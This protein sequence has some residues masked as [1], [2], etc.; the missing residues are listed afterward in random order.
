MSKL[1]VGIDMGTTALKIAAF[2]TAG[3]LLGSATLEYTLYTP[4]SYFVESDPAVYMDA[5]EKGFAKLAE[6]GVPIKDVVAL[7]FSSQ[8]ETMFFVDENCKPLRNSISWMDNRA[9][10]Q[11][12]RLEKKYG[13]EL[14]YKHTG[15][16]SWGANWP[17]TKALWVKENEPEVWAKTKKILLIEDFIIYQLTGRYVA[18]CAMLT[19]TLYWDITTKKYWKLML[20]ELELTEDYFPEILEP[21]ELV[22][23]ILPDMAEKLGLSPDTQ[24]CTGAM[25]NAIGAL[26]VGAYRPGV[27]SE[28]IGST[29]AVCVPTDKVVYDPNQQMPVHYYT[30]KDTYMMHTFTS[31]GIC[32]RW[33]R[34][35]FCQMEKAMAEQ[36]G[37]DDYN[38]LTKQAE[39][40]PAGSDGLSFLPHLSGSLAPD[41]NPHATGIFMGITLM[42]TKGHFI[43]AIMESLGYLVRRNID[44]LEAMGLHIDEI[45]AFGGGSKSPLWNQ[46]NADILQ[47]TICVTS[48]KEAACLGAAIL[49]G[50]AVGIFD[51][52]EKACDSM[53]EVIARYEPSSENKAVYDH[54]YEIY[55]KMQTDC[56]QLFEMVNGND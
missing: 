19:S 34:D 6:K 30:M 20:D 1:L 39:N 17:A 24:I 26:G 42:H 10:E 33:F 45:R 32:M 41:V 54:G 46:I 4:Q 2:D 21:G 11:S 8:S 29:L 56:A 55:K 3:K 25:D 27:F 15:Q 23:K 22:G 50:Y 47:R 18:D 35:K 9:V 13:N 31:G 12:Q 7:G 52:I 43:R 36:L 16:V 28:S 44:A 49:A 40:I 38:L 37:E 5:I 48:S 14:C 53:V 51:S